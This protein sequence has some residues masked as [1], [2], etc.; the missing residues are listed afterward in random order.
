MSNLKVGQKIGNN[1]NSNNALYLRRLYSKI[2]SIN[3]YLKNTSCKIRV[4]LEHFFGVT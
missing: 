1:L 2:I 3:F 4:I